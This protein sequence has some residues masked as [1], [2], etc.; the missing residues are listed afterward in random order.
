MSVNI[1]NDLKSEI[2]DL[3]KQLTESIEHDNNNKLKIK[4]LEIQNSELKK[5]N[6]EFQ[7]K[8]QELIIKNNLV[9]QEDS[10]LKLEIKKLKLSI[11]S[12][13][14]V[15]A[16]LGNVI[17]N[18]TAKNINNEI[19]LKEKIE[20]KES[21]EKLLLVISEREAEIVKN[22]TYNDKKI[23]M[24]NNTI[25][26]LNGK[27]S[28][29]N[30]DMKDMQDQINAKDKELQKIEEN[31]NILAKYNLLKFEYEQYKKNIEKNKDLF[32]LNNEKLKETDK[33][34]KNLNDRIKKI[35]AGFNDL[36]TK[37]N[38]KVKDM[39]DLSMYVEINE[40]LRAQI[41]E[42]QDES[43]KFRKK[44][45]EQL[46]N[47]QEEN[48]KLQEKYLE[49]NNR[50]EDLQKNIDY[51]QDSLVQG[52]MQLNMELSELKSKVFKLETEKKTEQ[53]KYKEL[54]NNY[55]KSGENFM[56]IQ[57]TMT[58]L[59]EKDDF[60]ITLI[61]ERYIVL[62]NM[63]DL[64]KN[65]LITQNRE[66]IN[67]VKIL[68]DNDGEK[69]NIDMNNTFKMEI[70][71]LKDENKLL[72]NKLKDKENQI[73]Q[74]QKQMETLK[75]L[76]EENQSLKQNIK[77]NNTN[78]QVIVNELTA[79][80]SQLSEELLESRRRT[81]LLRSIPKFKK[82]DVKMKVDNTMMSAEVEKYQKENENLK[83]EIEHLKEE[84]Q[85]LVTEISM[86]KA[87]IA[88]DMFQKDSEISKYKSMAKKYKTMLEEKGL[89]KK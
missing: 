7:S 25:N 73:L 55:E 46:K 24:L 48:K 1:N 14:K 70:Q 18:D 21:N 80:N 8:L 26:E 50:A 38:I 12:P 28:D 58:K 34:N 66:L 4:D 88:N 31:K 68:N 49:E 16:S 29:L 72:Q 44:F 67:Q 15:L 30:H 40:N 61:E 76:Q 83:N 37:G 54:L 87:Q 78:F 5:R 57:K 64:E 60:D 74:F 19:L 45:E 10:N 27:L 2:E 9:Q 17:K 63:L 39:N 32:N 89:L 13:G 3:Q 79:K 22:N 77:E 53:D 81:T 35:E 85:K 6:M 75:I 59:R 52:T 69:N 62:E 42:M 84:N 20:L 23:S 56:N 51:L 33:L 86:Q 36:I 71:N 82:E 11:N 43:D 65:D 41:M 47:Y